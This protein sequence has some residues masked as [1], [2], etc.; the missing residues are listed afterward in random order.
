SE[1]AARLREVRALGPH[2]AGEDDAE[3]P[4]DRD[5]GLAEQPLPRAVGLAAEPLASREPEGDRADPV[6]GGELAVGVAAIGAGAGLREHRHARLQR[7]PDGLGQ[8]AL[9][10]GG[11]YLEPEP[12]QAAA[13]G[14][15]NGL[16]RPVPEA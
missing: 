15:R 4:P 14:E 10:P 8:A 3:P 13:E 9:E 7:S 16:P 6:Q 5:V 12:G 2:T 1:A 11:P